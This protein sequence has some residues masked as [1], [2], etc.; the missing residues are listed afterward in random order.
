[1]KKQIFI[2]TETTGLDTE[3]DKIVQ[4][5]YIYCENGKKKATGNLKGATI[6]KDFLKSI[7]K[8]VDKFDKSDKMYFIGH[9]SNFDSSFVREMFVKNGNNF[10]GAYFYNPVI[11]TMMIASYK[12]MLKNKRPEDFT[13]LGL[14]KYFKI[15]VDE[16]KLH[17]A[18]YDIAKTRELYLKL[19]K[20]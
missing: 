20:F 11:C 7:G 13:L 14:L 19:T 1:M 9:N 3:K 15:K 4:L 18:E 10:Y 12:F 17:D 8:F 2:D 5:A 16:N 6:Y